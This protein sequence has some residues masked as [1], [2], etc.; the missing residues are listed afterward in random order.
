[1]L[2]STS[3]LLQL[4]YHPLLLYLWV[5]P[6]SGGTVRHT[7]FLSMAHNPSH[8]INR[9]C[10]PWQVLCIKMTVQL[11]STFQF[12]SSWAGC[13]ESLRICSI[14][15]RESRTGRRKTMRIT[16]RRTLLTGSLTAFCLH[17]L[18]QVCINFPLYHCIYLPLPGFCF[19][20]TI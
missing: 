18:L 1:M 6:E 5:A 10:P 14:W 20:K 17:G 4:Q 19:F 2:D 16:R 8:F 11:R 15:D 13:L 12:I 7:A 3:T 9:Y